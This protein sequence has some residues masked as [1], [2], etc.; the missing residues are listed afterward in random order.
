MNLETA[1]IHPQMAQ[2]AQ[3]MKR[4]LANSSARAH[5]VLRWGQC[6]HA[7]PGGG[8]DVAA[9]AALKYR[10]ICVHLRHLR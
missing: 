3:M 7:P 2:M 9:W 4:F 10:S 8:R 5:L 1:A 6:Q